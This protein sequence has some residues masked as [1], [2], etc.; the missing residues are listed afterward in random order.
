MLN[1]KRCHLDYLFYGKQVKMFHFNT[2]KK[3]SYEKS[4]FLTFNLKQTTIIIFC[5]IFCTCS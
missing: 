2:I 3:S 1:N 4:F 5:C